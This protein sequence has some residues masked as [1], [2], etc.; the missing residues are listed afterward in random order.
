MRQEVIDSGY[1]Q[2]VHYVYMPF[3][4]PEQSRLLCLRMAA[5]SGI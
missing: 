4:A 2:R 5:F 1:W 3:H